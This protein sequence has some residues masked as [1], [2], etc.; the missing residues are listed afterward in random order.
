M[1]R[2]RAA[3][4]GHSRL[5]FSKCKSIMPYST[6]FTNNSHKTC[7]SA[8]ASNIVAVIVGSGTCLAARPPSRPE[9]ANRYNTANELHIFL[10]SAVASGDAGLVGGFFNTV[11]DGFGHSFVK[12]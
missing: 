3:R 6:L 1:R 10:R 11:G 7:R 9:P 8:S 4:G 5:V 2:A 12:D